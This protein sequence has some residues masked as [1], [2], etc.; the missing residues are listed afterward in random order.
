MTSSEQLRARAES[1]L[2]SDVWN[3]IET[4]SGEEISLGEAEQAWQHWRL[5][6]RVLQDVRSVSTTL[7]LL[8]HQ[9]TTPVLA[10]PTA[11]HQLYHPDGERASVAGA[12]D[13]GSLFCLS[14]RSTTSFE[15]VGAAASGPWWMQ[16]YV[17][18]ARDIAAA[19]VER[20]VQAG[21]SALVL[22]GDTPY[23]S[24]RARAGRAL[25]LSDETAMVNS[26]RHLGDRDLSHLEDDA[27]ITVEVI[28]W[29][30][31]LSGVPVLVKGVLRGDDALACLDA[32]AAGIVVS[33]HGARQLDR[34]VPTALAL[35]D[36]VSAVAGAAPVLVDG[37]IRSGYDV[38]T[39]LA[40]G[41]DAVM[42]GRPAIYGL[43][44][45]GADGVRD[46]LAGL[47]DE[48]AH[49]MGLAGVRSLDELD[50][51]YVTPAW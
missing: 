3:Y 14:T 28:E 21:A 35:P 1:V 34:A 16:V 25:P 36:V 48:V 46:V 27:G 45:G 43:A 22:T 24:R 17:T 6:P 7:D 10:A 12:T 20:A 4:G 38:L 33:N 32:G 19:M 42:V 40:L 39:A 18:A 29:L 31:D 51:S 26:A 5:R 50:A 44:T 37:G 13:A 2:S 8:G 49:L 15:D 9:L 47:T 30:A 11:F 23:L 41:A